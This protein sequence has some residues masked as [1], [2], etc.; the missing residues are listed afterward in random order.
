MK[1]QVEKLIPAALAAVRGKLLAPNETNKVYEEYD[2]YAASFGASVV[3]AGL[4]PTVSF[5]TNVHKQDPIKPRRY[6][7]LMALADILRKNGRTAIG[8][9]D[10][11]LLDFLDTDQNRNDKALKTE[12]IAASI[13]LKLAL[14]NFQHIKS[15][16]ES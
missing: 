5:Y 6:K 1:K 7:M 11:A 13:A 9:G 2:G 14:R 4:L 12:I 15:G 8:E 3:T 16:A 10:T